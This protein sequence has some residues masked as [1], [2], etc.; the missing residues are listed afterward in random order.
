MRE[1]KINSKTKYGLDKD[2]NGINIEIPH[3]RNHIRSGIMGKNCEIDNCIEIEQDHH[4]NASSKT[5]FG[6]ADIW[7]HICVNI[8]LPTDRYD[9]SDNMVS[10]LK[11]TIER[12]LSN[13]QL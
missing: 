1:W 6:G 12:V 11:E 9:I 8:S 5:S 2:S 13:Y 7:P 10:V 3:C 4:F